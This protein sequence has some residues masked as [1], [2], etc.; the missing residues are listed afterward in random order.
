VLSYYFFNPN[1]SNVVKLR[2]A[3]LLAIMDLGLL[4]RH[5]KA[6]RSKILDYHMALL[7]AYPPEGI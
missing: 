1:I 6:C 3:S 2:T 5:L 4:I 7:T